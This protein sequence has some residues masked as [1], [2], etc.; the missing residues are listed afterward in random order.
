[1]VIHGRLDTRVEARCPEGVSISCLASHSSHFFSTLKSYFIFKYTW[2]FLSPIA[3]RNMKNILT[4]YSGI[5]IFE[6]ALFIVSQNI[7]RMCTSVSRIG[8]KY[9]QLDCI[10]LQHA[11]AVFALSLSYVRMW[12]F[13]FFFFGGGVVKIGIN[14]V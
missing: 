1:M 6:L 3:S 8:K 14:Y 12:I 10:E 13:D 9:A 5:C 7:I 2:S 4:P 11:S